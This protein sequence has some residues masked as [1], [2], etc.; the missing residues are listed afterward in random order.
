MATR[1]DPTPSPGVLFVIDIY[2]QRTAGTEGQLYLLAETL[3]QRGVPCHLLVLRRSSW[4]ERGEFPCPWSSID[5]SSLAAPST[6]LRMWRAVRRLRAEGF[7]VGHVYFND[8]SI[9]APPCMK[10]AG[11]ATIISRRDMGYW[12]TTGY[13]TALRLTNR[14]VDC[15]VSNSAAVSAITGQREWLGARRRRVIYNGLLPLPTRSLPADLQPLRERG[16]LLAG[17]VANA[18]P[19]K[20]LDDLLEAFGRIAADC[21]TLDLVFVG[22]GDTAPLAR[23]AGEL[24]LSDRVHLLGRRDDAAAVMNALD[25]GVLCSESEGFSNAILEY[26]R[27]GLP[28]ICTDTG[29]NAEAVEH[30][31]NGLLYAVGEIGSLADALKRLA[32]D[33]NLRARYGADGQ[34]RIERRFSLERMIDDHLKLYAQLGARPPTPPLPEETTIA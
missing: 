19:I 20:R 16:R 28:V 33:A 2:E 32:L 1:P 31:H 5:A 15:C 12:H 26:M 18:R 7:T 13:L 27:A 9:I 22:G 25:I 10:L 8:A 11:M 30:A 29:G 4:L 17:I 23:R 3:T 34:A 6:W 21:P 24:A 14:F